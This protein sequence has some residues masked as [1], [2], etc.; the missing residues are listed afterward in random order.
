MIRS[1]AALLGALGATVIAAAL[2]GG[3]AAGAVDAAAGAEH[4]VSAGY[5]LILTG[6]APSYSGSVRVPTISCSASSTGTLLVEEYIATATGTST[7]G[8][9]GLDLGMSCSGT[10][11]KYGVALDANGAT[12]LMTSPVAAGNTLKFTAAASSGGVSGK[13]TDVNTKKS[14]SASGGGG[15]PKEVAIGAGGVSPSWPPF[16]TI[17]FNEVMLDGKPLSASGAFRTNAGVE[18]KKHWVT[19]IS[20][21]KLSKAGDSFRDKYVTNTP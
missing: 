5:E 18:V 11:A 7:T 20:S 16:T 14:V 6:G 21:S 13:V 17:S 3:M 15:T 10:T 8:E 12:T 4:S 2:P 9:I 1:R 19:E